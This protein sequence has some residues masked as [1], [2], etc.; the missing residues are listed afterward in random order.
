MTKSIEEKV[1]DHLKQILKKLNIKFYTKNE[2]INSQIDS[3]LSKGVSKSGGQG[4]NY[5]DVKLLLCDSFGRNI[6]VMIEVKGLKNRLIK[7]NRKGEIELEKIR[8]KDS[9]DTAKI[10]YKKGDLNYSSIENYAVNGAFHYARNIL[11]Y[12]DYS[13]IIFIGVNGYYKGKESKDI[14]YESRAYY[15]SEKNNLI[16]KHIKELEN[17][18]TLLSSNNIDKLYD[19]LDKLSLSEEEIELLKTKAEIDL[20][21]K[22]KHIHQSIYDNKQLKIALTTNEKLY[23]FLGLI[24]AGLKTE[25]VSRLTIDGL[26]SNDDIE[27]NDGITILTR[28]RSFLRKK[29]SSIEKITMITSLLEPVFKKKPLWKPNNGESIIKL[30]YKEILDDIIPL[31]ESNLRLDF[32]G[33]ILNSLNDWVSI[34]NDHNNDVV[35]TPRYITEL[36]AK[37]ARTNMNSYVWDSAMGSAGFL[38]SAMNIMIEDAKS[39]IKDTNKLNDKIKSIKENQL[40]GIEILGNIYILAVLNMI[41][42]GDGSSNIIQGDSHEEINNIN[43]PANVFLLNP[44]YSADGH[45]FIFVEEAFSKMNSGYGCVLIQE[46]AGSG[47]GLPYTKNILKN[48]TLLASIHMPNK[49]FS[50]K[51]G[52]Q[53]SIFLFEINRPHEKDD[54]VTFID[55]SNDGYSRLSR[56]KST[57]EV[58]LKNTDHAQERYNE[59]ISI[60]LGKK[61]DTNYYTEKNKLLIKDSITLNGDDWTYVQHLEND[62]KVEIDDFTKVVSDHLIFEI[63]NFL[64]D[65]E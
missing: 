55:F 30:L 37:L 38:V 6:P 44:P 15:L 33:K 5:P 42:M 24:M 8:T 52:V 27:D 45:G 29:N 17:D 23:L 56:K 60:V 26:S 47:Q 65:G 51:A 39:K 41:L 4:K 36:M 7:I 34:E 59:I 10:K 43:F 57:Q 1:E 22:V 53:T 3:A 16:P 14:Q 13:E 61:V 20:E 9:P 21:A 31:L 25:G 18:F 19:I 32:T 54:L 50:G 28:V 40:L 46:S 35:L 11:K 48:N 58:N 63:Q 64:K 12:S 2:S 62:S 49:L